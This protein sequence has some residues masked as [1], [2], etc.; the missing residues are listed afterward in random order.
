MAAQHH[1]SG[2]GG[3]ALAGGSWVVPFPRLLQA[4]AATLVATSETQPGLDH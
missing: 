4:L 2:C 3:V 1:R